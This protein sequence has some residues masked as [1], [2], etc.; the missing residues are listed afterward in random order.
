MSVALDFWFDFSS[1]YG[2]M[3]AERID[4]LAARHGRE[5]RWRP[6]LLGAVFKHTGG[7]PL[8]MQPLKGPYSARDL[9][10]SARFLG[11][12]CKQPTAFPVSTHQ[13]CRVFYW[14]EARDAGQAREFA[15]AVLRAYFTEDLDV[16]Q[17]A[18]LQDIGEKL[19]I[20][21]EDVAGATGDDT[22]KNQLR[23]VC[24]GAI[25]AGVFGSPFVVI[26]GEPFWGVDRLPQ[27][28]R[29]LETGGF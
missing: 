27:S 13:A 28:E 12:P 9:E 15:Q 19:G 6:F 26:D 4:A 17:V 24:E 3:M 18:V 16:S 1:P 2:Y 14:L 5:V 11:R 29:W 23:E 8:S 7:Q 20:S 10:R 22:V 25:A 21:R